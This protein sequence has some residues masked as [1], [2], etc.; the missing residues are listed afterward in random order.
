[1]YVRGFMI[2]DLKISFQK[3]GR[4]YNY[5]FGTFIADKEKKLKFKLSV[6]EIKMFKQALMEFL[7]DGL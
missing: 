6:E 3:N 1:M 4:R 7:E 5:Q 2:E